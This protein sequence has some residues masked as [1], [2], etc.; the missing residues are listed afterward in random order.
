MRRSSTGFPPPR[1]WGFNLIGIF[2]W[3]LNGS[4]L[5]RTIPPSEQIGGFGRMVP[6]LRRVEAAIPPPIGLS[7]F[8]VATRE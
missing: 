2:G 4:L 6:A 8:A 3:W 1:I 7:L 5:R